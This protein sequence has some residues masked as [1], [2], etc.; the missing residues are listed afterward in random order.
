MRSPEHLRRHAAEA[1]RA[2]VAAVPDRLALAS[3]QADVL[4]E[5]VWANRVVPALEGEL[6][7]QDEGLAD[8]TKK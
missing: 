8:L 4:E 5:I 1:H 7:G 2:A 3:Y 6:A